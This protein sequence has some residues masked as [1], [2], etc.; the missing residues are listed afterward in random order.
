M[1][2]SSASKAEGVSIALTFLKL[3]SVA[4]VLLAAGTASRMGEGGKDKL[5]AE[6]DNV[7]LVR[8]SAIAAFGSGVSSVVAVVGHRHNEISATLSGIP[9]KPVYNPHYGSGMASSLIAGFSA[10]VTELKGDIGARQNIER[11]GVR[12]SKLRSAPQPAST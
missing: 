9:V 4:A 1:T 8:R 10:S 5:Q 6:F 2:S 7:P 11:S 3:P 12:S